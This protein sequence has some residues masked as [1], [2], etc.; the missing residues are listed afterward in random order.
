MLDGATHPISPN[1]ITFRS[2]LNQSFS[3]FPL[4]SFSFEAL[5]TL[6]GF[7]TATEE[8]KGVCGENAAAA[9]A[10]LEEDEVVVKPKA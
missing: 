4:V 1:P 2:L 3:N 9:A 10:A 6:R 8:R 7:L 5:G